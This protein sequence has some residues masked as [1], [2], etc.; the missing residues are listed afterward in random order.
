MVKENGC[1]RNATLVRINKR[2][3]IMNRMSKEER[4]EER[5]DRNIDGNYICLCCRLIYVVYGSRLRCDICGRKLKWQST[6]QIDVLKKEW[7][8]KDEQAYRR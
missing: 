3:N 8:I 5:E 7:A 1:V 2:G 6:A 4:I